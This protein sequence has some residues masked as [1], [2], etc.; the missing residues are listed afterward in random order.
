V[1]Q[2]YRRRSTRRSAIAFDRSCHLADEVRQ[3][4]IPS[5]SAG[6]VGG[7]DPRLLER[8]GDAPRPVEHE[9][10]RATAGQGRG[11]RVVLLETSAI[12]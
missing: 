6:R 7:N 2:T 1:H 12:A 10:A 8:K 9:G 3:L 4:D 5:S 11:I